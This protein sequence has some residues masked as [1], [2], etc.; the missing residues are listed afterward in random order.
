MKNIKRL[1]ITTLTLLLLLNIPV[2]SH[3]Y[4]NYISR[5]SLLNNIQMDI[6]EKQF[7]MPFSIINDILK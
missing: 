3:N 4:N 5:Y 2:F 6:A 7:T 1:T